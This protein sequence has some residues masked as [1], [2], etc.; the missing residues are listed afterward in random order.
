MTQLQTADT[1]TFELVH[2]VTRESVTHQNRYG[3]DLAAD[4]YLPSGFDPAQIYPGLVVGPPYGGVKEQAAGVYASHLAARGFAALAFDP[5][6]NGF[7]GG[8]ARHL[9]SPELF[10][11][12][13][14]AGVDYLGSRPFV[15]RERIGAIGV[16]GS[17]SFAIAAAQIDRRIK[18]VATVSMYDISR[19]QR[20]GFHD[21][22]TDADRNALLDRIGQQRWTDFESGD[23]ALTPRGAP[24]EVDEH[25]DPISREF[26]EYYSTPRGFHPNSI[27]AFTVTSTPAFMNL[28]LLGHIHTISPRPLLFVFGENAHSRYFSEDAYQAAAEPKEIHIVP[29][30]GHVDL[31][32]K[33]DLI[34]LDKLEA[35][36][37]EHLS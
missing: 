18:A 12:D 17:G 33:T 3:I 11:E 27:T 22:M 36:F 34:P 16:C 10:A 15:D 35:F 9:S 31:Y 30:A 24:E 32:D 5:S 4:L 21:S 13:F 20:N 1:Y 25:T 23:A 37:T 26:Y 28:P 19:V 29:G 14:S 7:S 6:Y 2:G 8:S